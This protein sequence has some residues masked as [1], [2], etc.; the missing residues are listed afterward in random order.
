MSGLTYEQI[1]ANLKVDPST[2][3]RTVR[4]FEGDG[5]VE[6]RKQKTLTVYDE[7]LIIQSVLDNPPFIYMNSGI[8]LKRQQ[9]QTLLN[10]LFAA[11]YIVRSWLK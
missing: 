2:V 5:T 7:L 8:K 4:K 1:A 9:V 3:W 10:Q 6:A 11:F